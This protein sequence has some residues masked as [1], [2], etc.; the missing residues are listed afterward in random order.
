MKPHVQEAVEE[1]SAPAPSRPGRSPATT[2]GELSHVA[3]NLFLE[4]GFDETTV[5]QIVRAAGI[6]RRT[7]FR[8]FASKNELPWGD[9][10]SLLDAMRVRLAELDDDLPLMEALRV[11][12]IDFNTFPE[13]EL[14][15]HRGR[16]WLL[17]NVPSLTA[18]STLKYAEW[19]AVIAEYVARRR[20]EN[21]ADLAP[22]TIAWACLGLCIGAYERWL[23]HEEANL[24][25]LLDTAFLTAESV[26]GIAE[27]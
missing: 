21:P 10:G 18:Y 7:F 8:Y 26:F 17:L 3:L 24:L 25:E 11:A 6:G 15:Y 12:V 27:S 16:M 23:S 9:F 1:A 20:G 13:A 2:H 19:R 14:P 22:Q 4:Q 5:D